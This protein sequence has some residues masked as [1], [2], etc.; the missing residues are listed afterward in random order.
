[1]EGSPKRRN[2]CREHL[3]EKGITS[4]KTALHSLSDTRWSSCSDNSYCMVSV[5]PTLLS[6]FQQMSNENQNGVAIGLLVRIK[7]FDFV[8]ASLLQKCFSLNRHASKCLQSEERDLVTAVIHSGRIHLG[9]CPFGIV[10]IRDGVHSGWCPFEI[11]PIRDGAHSGWC[12]FGMVPIGDGAIRDCVPF[13]IVS[14]RDC[15]F[16]GRV[17]DLST[18]WAPKSVFENLPLHLFADASGT[19]FL[20]AFYK[21]SWSLFLSV[22]LLFLQIF[23]M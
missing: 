1:M 11:V 5:Y 17:Q 6:M 19:K 20:H 14:I 3:K 4:G 7:Q 8:A 23:A 10:F 16:R 12:P 2:V 9:W 15:I 21:K 13:E 22:L 18:V